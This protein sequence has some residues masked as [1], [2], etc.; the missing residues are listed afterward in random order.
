MSI[1]SGTRKADA[2]GRVV[3]PADFANAQVVV[4]RISDDEVRVRKTRALIKRIS[5]RELLAGLPE[6]E[7]HE[8]IDTGPPVGGEAW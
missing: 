6:G 1:H 2:E 5:L 3:L 7:A 8:E 4:E